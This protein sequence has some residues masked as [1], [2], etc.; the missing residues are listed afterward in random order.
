MRRSALSLTA[1][2]LLGVAVVGTTARPARAQGVLDVIKKKAEAAK[3]AAQDSAGAAAEGAKN[4]MEGAAKGVTAPGGPP[5]ATPASTG[6]APAP[7]AAVSQTPAKSSARVEEQVMLTGDA[8]TQFTLSPHGQHVAAKVLKGSRT[9]MMYDGVAGPP[10]DEIPSAGGIGLTFSDDG[11]HY[12]YVARQGQQWVVM[13]DGKEAARREPFGQVSG[14][15]TIASIG[16]TPGGKHLYFSSYDQ[17]RGTYPWQFYFDGKPDAATRE[18]AQPAFSPDGEHYAYVFQVNV[19]TGNPLPALMVDGKRATYVGGDPR[20]TA[21]SHLYTTIGVPRAAAID[22]LLDGKA[23]MR[24]GGVE[25]HMAPSGPAMLASVLVVNPQ[26]QRNVFLTIGN[27]RIPNTDCHGSGAINGVYFSADVKHWAIRCQDSN[28][29]YW[30]M[31][32]GKK[33]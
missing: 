3:K 4:T 19:E 5:P 25:L 6:R 8:G 28:S 20:W 30:V 21:D 26:G 2:I 15:P 17:A 29:A 9:A 7:T 10:F 23:I 16:F 33:G 31:A 13:A 22:V 1:V 11:G 32:D 24:V 27:R 12:A 18:G 14:N